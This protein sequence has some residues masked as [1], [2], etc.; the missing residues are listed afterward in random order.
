MNINQI[1]MDSTKD[2][3]GYK[4]IYNSLNSE[5]YWLVWIDD[6]TNV[7]GF[8]YN[9][10]SSIPDKEYAKLVDLLESLDFVYVYNL[11]E[12]NGKVKNR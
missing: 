4:N 12:K 8:E 5:H 3:K 7:F 11:P 1:A 10:N 9:S 6:N 2:K